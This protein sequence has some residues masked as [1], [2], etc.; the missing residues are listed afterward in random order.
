MD[1]LAISVLLFNRW[2]AIPANP[3]MMLPDYWIF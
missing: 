1:K 2:S 3:E